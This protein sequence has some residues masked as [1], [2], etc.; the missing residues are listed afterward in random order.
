MKLLH[1]ESSVVNK[2]KT[3]ILFNINT[4]IL[5]GSKYKVSSKPLV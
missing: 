2:K 5:I 1:Y 4:I 3:S